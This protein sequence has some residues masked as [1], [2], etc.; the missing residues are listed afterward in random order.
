MIPGLIFFFCF[1]RNALLTVLIQNEPENVYPSHQPQ[2]K[3]K[4]IGY[5]GNT[6]SISSTSFR[7]C[8]SHENGARI[9]QIASADHTEKENK[10]Q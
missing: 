9:M 1:I 5:N 10:Q 2:N 3:Y 8:Y 6:S 7:L 4:L